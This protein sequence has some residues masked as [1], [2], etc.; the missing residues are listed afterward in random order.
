MKKAIYSKVGD[1]EA[2]HIVTCKNEQEAIATK[3]LY[4]KQDRYEVAHGYSFPYGFPVYEIRD[5]K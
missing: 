3:R 1:Y 4:E 5:A 2:K